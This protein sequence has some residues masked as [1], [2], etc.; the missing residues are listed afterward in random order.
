MDYLSELC[1]L[2]NAVNTLKATNPVC[3]IMYVSCILLFL[4]SVLKE[5]LYM[6]H[7]TRPERTR[8]SRDSLAVALII[9]RSQI[10]AS[11]GSL[12]KHNIKD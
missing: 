1:P 6:L 5:N 12:A 10:G 11:L 7:I 8:S 9:T 3:I 2:D 4:F